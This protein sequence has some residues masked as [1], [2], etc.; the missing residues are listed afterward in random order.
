MTADSYRR[1]ERVLFLNLKSLLKRDTLRRVELIEQLYY[2]ASPLS[3]EYLKSVLDCSLPALLNDIKFVNNKYEHPMIVK[4]KGLYELLLPDRVGL[5]EIYSHVINT[6]AEMRLLEQLLY[7]EHQTITDLAEYL[8]VS[9]SNVHRYLSNLRKVVRP[10]KIRVCH[11]PL[12]LEG[13]EAAIRQLYFHFFSQ[14]KKS[15]SSF[16]DTATNEAVQ[17]LVNDITLLNRMPKTIAVNTRMMYSF[18]VGLWRTKNGHYFPTDTLISKAFIDADPSVINACRAQLER[19]G[20]QFGEQEYHECL[21]LLYGDYLLMTSS[22]F[23]K[24]VE[25]NPK[26]RELYRKHYYLISDIE[27]HTKQT[28]SKEAADELCRT[29]IT[30]HSLF[31][32]DTDFIVVLND[33]KRAF[34]QTME[35]TR[36][37]SVG[38]LRKIIENF[39]SAYEMYQTEDFIINYLYLIIT[40][41]PQCLD[42]MEKQDPQLEILLI[43][44]MSPTHEMFLADFVKRNIVGNLSLHLSNDLDLNP[45]LKAATKPFDII[46]TTITF[47]EDTFDI[48]VLAVESHPSIKTY[49]KIQKVVDQS[50]A[51]KIEGAQQ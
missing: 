42:L 35:P 38:K 6:S 48:P 27:S 13:D 1:V 16:F 9:I 43:S 37:R 33:T 4:E 3:S 25:T 7:E 2:S 17:T 22:I 50:A 11:R 29:L 40:T 21:W 34:I 8:F 32:P 26:I 14:K 12:R 18:Y 51:K 10:W 39:T 41:Y 28:L 20:F 24:A 45:D 19:W 46:I 5:D 44:D 31:R 49:M 36:S 15:F 23:E 47:S 30:A